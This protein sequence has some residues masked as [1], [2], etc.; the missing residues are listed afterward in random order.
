MQ[1]M[2]T[3]TGVRGRKD[4]TSRISCCREPFGR[5]LVLRKPI[6]RRLRRSR[7]PQGGKGHAVTVDILLEAFRALKEEIKVI[8]TE[9]H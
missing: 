2:G 5:W 9:I 4:R 7:V 1:D 6:F 3:M 8:K